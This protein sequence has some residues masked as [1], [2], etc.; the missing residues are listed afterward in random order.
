MQKQPTLMEQ[1]QVALGVR[2]L[3]GRSVLSFEFTTSLAQH[4]SGKYRATLHAF[5]NEFHTDYWSPEGGYYCCRGGGDRF[6]DDNSHIAVALAE[7]YEI[8]GEQVFLDRAIETFDFLLTGEAP[9]ANGGSYWSVED[10]TFLDSTAAI[11]GARASLMIY[12]A[13]NDEQ[14]LE[15]ALRRYNWARDTT[16]LS[17]GT[18]LEKLYLTGP[19]VGQIGDF[20]LVHYAGYGIAANVLFCETTGELEYLEEAQRIALTSLGRYFDATTGQINDEGFWAYEL[21]DGLVELYQA[22]G[23]QQWYDA[24]IRAMDWLYENKR[25][26]NGHYGRFWG[27]GGPQDVALSQWDLNDQAPVARAFLRL[28]LAE[29]P[30]DS[31]FDGDVDGADFL[32]LQRM[33]ITP[34]TLAVW[35]DSYGSTSDNVIGTAVASIATVPE[36]SSFLIL[37]GLTIGLCTGRG[38]FCF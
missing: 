1:L 35:P 33:G 29:V 13:T 21:V 23:D 18:F 10:H 37:T 22:D 7:A 19:K 11:Q 26:P 5:S 15:H 17:S 3:H 25:D 20:D 34:S 6:Y 12:K 16:Q 31:D 38:F 9:G 24:A 32:A 8:T 36:P 27:R 28:G 4:D 2:L 30:G 14:Y